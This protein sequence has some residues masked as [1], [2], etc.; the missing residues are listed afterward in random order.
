[1]KDGIY[2]PMHTAEHLLNQ[3]MVRL[4]GTGRCFSSHIE[5]RKS[6]CDYRFGR[7]LS[8]EEIGA[9]EKAVNDVIAEDLPVKE[10]FV[11]PE[12]ARSIYARHGI[13]QLPASPSDQYRTIA[14]GD[15]DEILCYGPHV[16]STAELGI[17]KI[18]SSSFEN[19]VL[20]IRYKLK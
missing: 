10:R 18:I 20:R 3:A 5:K 2:P 9:V 17:F 19:G 6:K 7:E 15:Y 13:E 14:V 4:L 11:S 8:A 1:M 12:E 16:R